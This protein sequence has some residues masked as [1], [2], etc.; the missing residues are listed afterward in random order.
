MR[1]NSSRWEMMPIMKRG[2]D[3]RTMNSLDVMTELIDIG[4]RHRACRRA[5]IALDDVVFMS[6]VNEEEVLLEKGQVIE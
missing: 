6:G 5:N 2:W 1:W 4:E 3:R